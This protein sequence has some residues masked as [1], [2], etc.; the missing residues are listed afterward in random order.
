MTDTKFIVT[1]ADGYHCSMGLMLDHVSLNMFINGVIDDVY[2]AFTNPEYD[3]TIAGSE[4]PGDIARDQFTF[5][6]RFYNYADHWYANIIWGKV[7][8]L[9]QFSKTCVIQN[10]AP[11][12]EVDALMLALDVAQ[13]WRDRM[14]TEERKTH[15]EHWGTSLGFYNRD[16]LE[17]VNVLKERDDAD[18]P[19]RM[20]VFDYE[21]RKVTIEQLPPNLASIRERI[22]SGDRGHMHTYRGHMHTCWGEHS[23]YSAVIPDKK[24]EIFGVP[25]F[26]NAVLVGT[27]T[28]ENLNGVT[29]TFHSPTIELVDCINQ[30]DW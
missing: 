29:R 28:L 20:I 4:D 9:Y 23:F 13:T 16:M 21:N 15:G 30:V 1:D 7:D 10:I 6:P 27:N 11:G 22:Q 5:L 24:W 19:I 26:G 8:I 12:L 14:V 2:S 18:N 17:Y 25:M 3:P